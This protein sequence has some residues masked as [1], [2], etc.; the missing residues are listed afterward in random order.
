MNSNRKLGLA[1]LLGVVIGVAGSAA[2]HARQVTP[3]PGYLFAEVEVT[4][5]ATFQKYAQQVAATLTP[6]GGHYL[7][8]G[9]KITALE[10]E[11]PK[12][13]TVIAFD[14]AQ[15]VND[16]YNSPAYVAIKPLR[17][18]STKSRLFIDEGVPK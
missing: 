18:S 15:K 5:P 7:V 4:D 3:P 1:V 13:F 10:G 8:R 17:T 2:I 14:S 11:P 12:A 6:F 16:W 9:G